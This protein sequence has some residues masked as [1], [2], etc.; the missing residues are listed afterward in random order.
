M[1][2][3]ANLGRAEQL[4][5]DFLDDNGNETINTRFYLCPVQKKVMVHF[6][7]PGDASSETHIPAD[8]DFHRVPGNGTN[9]GGWVKPRDIWPEKYDRVANGGVDAGGIAL[10][11]LGLSFDQVLVLNRYRIQSVEDLATVSDAVG[12]QIGPDYVE[13]RNEAVRFLD[14]MKESGDRAALERKNAELERRLAALEQQ[15]IAEDDVI[16]GYEHKSDDDL[17]AMLRELGVEPDGRWKRKSL[18]ERLAKLEEEKAA[19]SGDDELTTTLAAMN[20]SVAA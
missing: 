16:P 10:E 8:Q 14:T 6:A 20:G 3:F 17:R 12:A 19:S 18:L 13:M 9:L 11:E 5:A 1:N 2:A 15:K 7:R 4:K